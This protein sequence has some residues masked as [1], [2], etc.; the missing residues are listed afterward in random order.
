VTHPDQSNAFGDFV[1]MLSQQG[2][3][4]MAQA[5]ELLIHEAI[6]RQ[7]CVKVLPGVMTKSR[8]THKYNN[9]VN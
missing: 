4:G 9:I 7:Q 2:F 3:D 8:A 1:P 5:I 6:K